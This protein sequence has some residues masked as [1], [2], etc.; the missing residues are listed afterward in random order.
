MKGDICDIINK[1]RWLKKKKI[2]ILLIKFLK[3][4]HNDVGLK[5][6]NFKFIILNRFNISIGHIKK[7]NLDMVLGVEY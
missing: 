5:V 2:A 3:H 7:Q 1:L 4:I 6:S